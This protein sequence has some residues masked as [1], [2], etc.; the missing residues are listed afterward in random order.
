MF[1]KD[2]IGQEKA[3]KRLISEAKEGRIPH[4]QLFCGAEGVGKLAIAIAYARYINCNNPNDEDACGI[5]PNCIKFNKLVHPD[6]HFVFPIVKKKGNNRA[7]CDDY[8]NNWRE[9]VL[10]NPYFNLNSWNREIGVENQQSII[11]AT[12][13]EEIL[14]KLSFKSSQGGYKS[15]IVWLPEKMNEECSNKLLK[16]LE[17]PPAKTLFLLVSEQPDALLTTILSR[18]QRINIPAVGEKDILNMV[19]DKFGISQQMAMEIAHASQGSVLKAIDLINTNEEQKEFFDL[20]VNL[21]RLCYAR[22]IREMKQWS[23]T[24]AGM[25]RERQKNFLNYCQNMIRENFIYNF[26]KDELNYMNSN[27][28]QFS[29]KF[30]P[31]INEKNIF[32]IMNELSEAQSHIE[33]NVNSK[34]VFF[35]FSLKMIVLLIQK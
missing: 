29:L 17:E 23:E 2:I 16:I 27:E 9:F 33:Q 8:I 22:K 26:H 15:V 18:C 19:V 20:F 24:L 7:I 13:S 6:L 28:K 1:F 3:K 35:D 12:E 21:M 31:F 10:N 4:A 11:Y 25:G 32:G 30:S 14:K 34:M 5:C